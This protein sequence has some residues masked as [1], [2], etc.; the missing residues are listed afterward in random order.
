MVLPDVEIKLRITHE[1]RSRVQR[2]AILGFIDR[3]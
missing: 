2:N 1:R 3:K